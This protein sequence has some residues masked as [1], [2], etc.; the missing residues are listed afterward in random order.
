MIDDAFQRGIARHLHD[1]LGVPE[2]N[3]PVPNE[4]EQDIILD[5]WDEV[6]GR[7]LAKVQDDLEQHCK[8]IKAEHA[9]AAAEAPRDHWA[10][11][12]RAR[13]SNR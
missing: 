1:Y 4:D 7:V 6:L 12:A 11:P 2:M 10:G 5:A 13:T 3:I 8:L 9:A